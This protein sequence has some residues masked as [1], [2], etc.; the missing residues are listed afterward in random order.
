M[1]GEI[2]VV[3]KSGPGTLMQLYLLLSTPAETTKHHYQLNLKD[4]NLTVS[5]DFV[6]LINCFADIQNSMQLLKSVRTFVNCGSLES[7]RN[8]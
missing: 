2:K 1:N 7:F 8:Y 6:T 3:K 4:H 5:F